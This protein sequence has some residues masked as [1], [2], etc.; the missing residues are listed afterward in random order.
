[1][2]TLAIPRG[3]AQAG[4]LKAVET[5]TLKENDYLFSRENPELWINKTGTTG[6]QVPWEPLLVSPCLLCL[7]AAHATLRPSAAGMAASSQ[8]LQGYALI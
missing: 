5:N 1:M 3:S 2:L 8:H 4:L 6:E 7:P